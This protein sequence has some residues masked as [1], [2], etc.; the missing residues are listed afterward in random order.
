MLDWQDYGYCH[1]VTE[2]GVLCGESGGC[3]VERV[4]GAV[5]REWGVLCGESGGCC[6]ERVGGAVWRE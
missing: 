2:W 5:W 1:A 6:V 3:C 4:G